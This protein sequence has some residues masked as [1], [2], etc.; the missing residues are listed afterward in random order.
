[1]FEF[2]ACEMFKAREARSFGMTGFRTNV[3]KK[4]DIIDRL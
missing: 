2:E 4:S 1:M 3:T